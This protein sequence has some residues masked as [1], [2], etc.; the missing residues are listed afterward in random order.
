ME[1]SVY[2]ENGQ[3]ETTLKFDF[4]KDL[5]AKNYDKLV[6][7]VIVSEQN[8]KRQATAHTK[9][10]GIVSGGGKKPW[11]Q[12]GTGRAR[13]GSNRSPIWRG[14]GTVF[15]PLK[16]RNYKTKV[17]KKV[18]YLAKLYLMENFL[19][20]SHLTN[21]CFV[22]EEMSFSDFKTKNML[23]FLSKFGLEKN[24]KRTLIIVNKEDKNSKLA[25]RNL[26]FLEYKTW[27]TVSV[28]DLAVAKYLFCEL[29]VLEAFNQ[30]L[31][32]VFPSLKQ[33]ASQSPKQEV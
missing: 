10:R 18:Y 15:G 12:K 5:G 22:F 32:L 25:A 27:D 20:N 6:H 29:H 14:G 28:Y 8:S 33:Q 2:K 30:Q 21:S 13:H 16:T 24:H 1:I 9:T 3:V 31:S 17:N 7:Q 26:P 4:V 19:T 11:R 23:E